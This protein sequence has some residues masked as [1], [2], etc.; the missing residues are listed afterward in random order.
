M[1]SGKTI[2]GKLISKEINYI[3]LDSDDLI[4]ENQKKNNKWNFS[5]Q[6]WSIF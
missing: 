6:W 2:L 3:H 5:S 1:G 4:E